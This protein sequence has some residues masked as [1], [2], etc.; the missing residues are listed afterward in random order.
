MY[1]ELLL[2][3]SSLWNTI[4]SSTL[5]CSEPVRRADSFH[6]GCASAGKFDMTLARLF[7]DATIEDEYVFPR[8]RAATW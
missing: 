1:A 8:M 4:P 2:V 5:D 6:A 7:S 3:S